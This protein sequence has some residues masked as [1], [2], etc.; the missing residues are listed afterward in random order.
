MR[1]LLL[2]VFGLLAATGTVQSASAQAGVKDKGF[3]TIE[4][5]NKTIE[6]SGNSYHR[7]YPC[8]GRAVVIQGTDHAITLTGTCA[9]LELSGANNSVILELAKG[10]QLEVAGTGQTVRWRSRGE[11]RQDISGPDNKIVREPMPK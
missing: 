3:G 2:S 9:S 6:I 7:S 8:D 5:N 10:G 1:V 11:I 4:I